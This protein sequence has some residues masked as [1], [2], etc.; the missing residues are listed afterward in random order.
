MQVGCGKQ[1][2]SNWA[3][4][5]VLC[6]A[7]CVGAFWQARAMVEASGRSLAVGHFRFLQMARDSIGWSWVSSGA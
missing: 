6:C 2:M 4:S 7:W 1:M 5:L 3:H